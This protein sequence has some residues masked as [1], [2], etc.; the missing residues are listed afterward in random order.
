MNAAQL[1]RLISL[2]VGAT[3]MF[4]AIKSTLLVVDGGQRAIVFDRRDGIQ[5]GVLG[6]GMHFIVPLLQKPYVFD[7]R[8]KAKSVTTETGSKDL[9]KVELTLRLLYRPDAVRL[10]MI[11]QKLNFNFDERVLPSIGTEVLKAVVAQYDAAEL[12]TQREIVSQEIR[13]ALTERANEWGILLDDVSITHLGFSKEYT[14]AVEAKQVMQQ[15]AERHKFIVQKNEQERIAAVIRGEGE[16]EAAELISQA[17]KAG[18]GFLELRRIEAAREIARTLSSSPNITYVPGGGQMLMKLK[19][20]GAGGAGSGGSGI[21][22]RFQ[23]R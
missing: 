12:I 22:D 2:G 19:I 7:V 3:F 1:N 14:S 9:Q 16:A 23:K 6:P 13:T 17:M 5:E 11:Y 15:D 21:A 8:V 4:S 10:P 18:D 20:D